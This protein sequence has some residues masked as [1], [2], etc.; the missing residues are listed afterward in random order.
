MRK[1]PKIF[2]VKLSK[3]ASKNNAQVCRYDFVTFSAD[4]G[5][6]Q[7]INK[8]NKALMKIKL[9][10]I[11]ISGNFSARSS[12]LVPPFLQ[13]MIICKRKK[14]KSKRAQE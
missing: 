1:Y 3:K 9:T 13:A 4:L 14:K 6:Y 2:Q 8:E 12:M 11:I 5:M 7:K 10:L